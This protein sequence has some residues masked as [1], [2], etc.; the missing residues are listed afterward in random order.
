[1]KHSGVKLIYLKKWTPEKRKEFVTQMLNYF[2]N[3]YAIDFDMLR[4]EN[5]LRIEDELN[6]Q[7]NKEKLWSLDKGEKIDAPNYLSLE[8]ADKATRE[9]FIQSIG[10]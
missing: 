5:R 6:H 7:L 8:G 1:M 4:Y 9:T 3:I 2:R 10:A